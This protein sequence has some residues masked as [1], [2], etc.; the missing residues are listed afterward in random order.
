M[1]PPHGALHDS[2][3]ECHGKEGGQHR[4]ETLWA[5][6]GVGRLC[7]DWPFHGCSAGGGWGSCSSLCDPGGLEVD[8]REKR[9]KRTVLPPPCGSSGGKQG[10]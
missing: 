2:C 3:A 6:E 9:T 10:L 5:E 7:L 8:T 4:Q 1:G